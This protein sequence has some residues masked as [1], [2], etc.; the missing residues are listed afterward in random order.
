MPDREGLRNITRFAGGEGASGVGAKSPGQGWV[1]TSLKTVAR[2]GASLLS[3]TFVPVPS[4]SEHSFLCSSPLSEPIVRI[5]RNGLPKVPWPEG[6][7]QTVGCSDR[8]GGNG[9]LN[10]SRVAR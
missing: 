1:G 9:R 6:F 8:V 4:P 7:P 10:H 5:S 2:C 3:N